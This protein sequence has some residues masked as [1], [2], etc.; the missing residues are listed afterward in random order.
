MTIEIFSEKQKSEI[1]GQIKEIIAEKGV[2]QIQL[3][4]YYEDKDMEVFMEQIFL[5][6]AKRKIQIKHSDL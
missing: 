1:A 5:L 3:T 4:G 6:A 2:I